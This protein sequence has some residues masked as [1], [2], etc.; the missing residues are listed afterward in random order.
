MHDDTDGSDRSC[1]QGPVWSTR[2]APAVLA[3]P[4]RVCREQLALE[5]ERVVPTIGEGHLVA[6][7]ADPVTEA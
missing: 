7:E 2:R 4:E 1:Q 3:G 6:D 5:V